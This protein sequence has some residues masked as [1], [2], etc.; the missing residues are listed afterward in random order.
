VFSNFFSFEIVVLFMRR[1]GKIVSSGAGHTVWDMQLRDVCL[2]LQ[3]HTK[4]M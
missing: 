2:R 4:N 3:T 1:C